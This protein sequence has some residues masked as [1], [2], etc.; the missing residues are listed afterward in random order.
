MKENWISKVYHRRLWLLLWGVVLLALNLSCTMVCEAKASGKETYLSSNEGA[1]DYDFYGEPVS[2][3]LIA[4]A[5]GYIRI[6]AL[7]TGYVLSESFDTNYQYQSQEYIEYE[8]PLFGGFY[9][10]TDAYYLV[11]GQNNLN[12]KNTKEVLRVVRYDRNWNRTGSVSL[13]GANTTKPFH[14]GSL[15]MAEQDGYLYIRTCHEMYTCSDGYNHQGNLTVVVKL[16]DFTL[17]GYADFETSHSFNQYI[18][19]DDEGNLITL[20]H[21]DANPERAAL[22]RRYNRADSD[23]YPFENGLK[24]GYFEG[25]DNER[26][27]LITYQGGIGDNDTRSAMGGMEYSST[28]YLTA[29]NSSPQDMEE[30]SS[31]DVR[32]VYVTVTDKVDFTESGTT[33]KWFTNYKNKDHKYA[34]NPQLVKLSDESFLLLWEE[35]EGEAWYLR[36]SNGKIS[37]VFIDGEG[38]AVSSVYTVKGRLSDCKPVVYKGKVMWFVT[39]D[40]NITFYSVNQKGKLTK[41]N[42]SYPSGMIVYPCAIENC[43]MIFT[44]VGSINSSWDEI[45]KSIG[46]AKGDQVLKKDEDYYLR[47]TSWR[48]YGETVLAVTQKVA[49]LGE[50]YYGETSFTIEPI[51]SQSILNSVKITDQGVKLSWERESGAI[52]YKIYRKIGGGSYECVKTIKK[53]RTVTWTDTDADQVG[54]QYTYYI[55]AFTGDGS[56]Y[57][58]ADKSRKLSVTLQLAAPQLTGVSNLADGVQ[59]QWKSVAGAKKY[60]VFKKVGSGSWKKVGDTTSTELTDKTAESGTTYCYT[61]RCISNDGKS[62]T[63]SYDAKGKTIVY[64][65]R[66]KISELSNQ[67]DG[68]KVSWKKVSGAAGYQIQYSADN[69]FSKAVS[70][71]VKGADTLSEI[72]SG[73]SKGKTYYVR[74]RAYTTVSGKKYYSAWSS[75]KKFVR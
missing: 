63:S 21:G 14:A 24:N 51:R 4:D 68:V 26:V 31:G 20:D 18:L 49:A 33:I 23:S 28:S 70:V 61:V 3:Y 45:S 8:L 32:N 1:Q 47:D 16:D 2:S 52:G 64:L 75:T 27:S 57:Y 55:K 22:L 6:S 37:Y 74:I 10:G 59:I 25:Y 34:S 62:Y 53:N 56:K 9:A 11:F 42:G 12:E 69:S 15:R 67:K 40:E 35:Y 72:I 66:P 5:S 71:K 60:R 43:Q 41:N 17:A 44:K 39:D 19:F 46:M 58:Y 13:K 50:F 54:K 65:S 7:D 29:G 48:Y 30:I 73:L 38:N 36:E